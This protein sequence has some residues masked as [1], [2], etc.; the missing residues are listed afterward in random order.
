MN[1]FVQLSAAAAL[2]A[3]FAL[4]SFAQDKGRRDSGDKKVIQLTNERDKDLHWTQRN[5]P[6]HANQRNKHKDNKKVMH[7][8]P[9]H[10]VSV[11][12]K[13]D[14]FSKNVNHEANRE[15]KD[16]N[17]GVNNASKSINHTFQGKKK[18]D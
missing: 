17:H 12:G 13:T 16:F 7:K 5:K 3:V 15:S 2:L 9:P 6:K 1:K 4:P 14:Q 11:T 8:S 18:K 10:Q